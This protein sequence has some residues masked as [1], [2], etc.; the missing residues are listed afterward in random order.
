MWTLWANKLCFYSLFLNRSLSFLCFIN[1]T[2]SIFLSIL[3]YI[4]KCLTAVKKPCQTWNKL[5]MYIFIYMLK[6][7]VDLEA[8]AS[9]SKWGLASQAPCSP[10][11][12]KTGFTQWTTLKK[13][14]AKERNWTFSAHLSRT[15]HVTTNRRTDCIWKVGGAENIDTTGRW[16]RV[17]HGSRVKHKTAE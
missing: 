17:S 5:Y 11:V 10:T 14:S 8:D 16:D 15:V 4:K 3:C 12:R 9:L 7:N 1:F 2:S 6:K 13:T